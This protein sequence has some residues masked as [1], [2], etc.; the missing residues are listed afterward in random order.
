MERAG[1][2]LIRE[3]LRLNELQKKELEDEKKWIEIGL[4][5]RVGEQR[6]NDWS[7]M[8]ETKGEKVFLRTR[9]VQWAKMSN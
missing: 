5:R 4:K 2:K 9:D 8:V 7:R 6:F 3:R 1:H